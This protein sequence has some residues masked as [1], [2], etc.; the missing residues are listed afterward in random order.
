MK[1]QLQMDMINWNQLLDEALLRRQKIFFQST[2]IE[3]LF[4]VE[5]TLIRI[6][7]LGALLCS[8]KNTNYWCQSY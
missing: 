5:V 7:V 1:L 3:I 2:K 8:L 4:E 6:L